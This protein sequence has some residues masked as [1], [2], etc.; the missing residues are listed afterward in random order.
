MI[1]CRIFPSGKFPVKNA[2]HISFRTGLTS[3][4]YIVYS[5]NN[6]QFGLAFWDELDNFYRALSGLWHVRFIHRG[7][8]QTFIALACFSARSPCGRVCAVASFTPHSISRGIV[9]LQYLYDMMNHELLP[10]HIPSGHSPP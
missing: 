5:S 6:Y 1:N 7:P 10:L 2:M 4:N 3:S 8:C 9:A